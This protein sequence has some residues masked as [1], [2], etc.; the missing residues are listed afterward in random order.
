MEK[1]ITVPL[2]LLL[3]GMVFTIVGAVF[4][5]MHWPMT[6]VLLVIGLICEA[7]GLILLISNAMNKL[8]EK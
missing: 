2:I 4:K 5:L 7:I 6:N 8:K 1:K 3:L